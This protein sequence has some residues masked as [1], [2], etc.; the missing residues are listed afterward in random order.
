MVLPRK[1]R[2]TISNIPC[3]PSQPDLPPS[4][5]TNV[6][7]TPSSTAPSSP[8]P[9]STSLSSDASGHINNNNNHTSN[10]NNNNNQPNSAHQQGLL[11]TRQALHTY[12]SNNH[13]VHYKYS[14]YGGSCHELPKWVSKAQFI[15]SIDCF[16]FCFC[17]IIYCE[18]VSY[19]TRVAS[20][21]ATK[22]V[23]RGRLVTYQTTVH[24]LINCCAMLM[25][26][27]QT[28]RKAFFMLSST[29]TYDLRC[30]FLCVHDPIFI[31][32]LWY[33]F[34]VF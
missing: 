9:S 12:K 17:C 1:F 15:I 5:H 3:L 14:A 16:L 31:L 8:S 26:F 24:I 34:R 20:A 19:R 13:I 29:S 25:S 30:F 6:S 4:A 2:T 28:S 33:S 27:M 10:N 32:F 7:N 22:H 11:L 18:C 21:N 23:Q